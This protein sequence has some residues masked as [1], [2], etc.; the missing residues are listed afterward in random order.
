LHECVFRI[1]TPDDVD[2]RFHQQPNG[3]CARAR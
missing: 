2:A 1:S 3:E